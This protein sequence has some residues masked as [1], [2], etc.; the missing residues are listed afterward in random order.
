[1][2]ADKT[3]L[4]A[5]LVVATDPELLTIGAESGLVPILHRVESLPLAL[6]ALDHGDIAAVFAGPGLSALDATALLEQA[7]FRTDAT[8]ILALDRAAWDPG[9][10]L[11][12]GLVQSCLL[13]PWTRDD[14]TWVLR[15]AVGRWRVDRAQA[16][17]AAA[18][19]AHR[20]QTV[21]LASTGDDLRAPLDTIVGFSELVLSLIEA[22]ELERL[23]GYLGAITDAATRMR[24]TLDDLLDMSRLDLGQSPPREDWIDVGDA[25]QAALRLVGPPAA[26]KRQTLAFSIADRFPRLKGDGRLLRQSL[27]HILTNATQY[28]PEGGHI[29][30]RAWVADGLISLA[31]ADDGVGIAAADIPRLLHPAH[32]GGLGLTLARGLIEMHGGRLDLT[33]E[34]GKGT[35]VQVTFPPD[36]CAI[37]PDMP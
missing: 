19:A 20:A 23:G 10:L 15:A 24:R 16:A 9:P 13:A 6:T 18:Q 35:R 31:V 30:V 17:R 25:I 27:L 21:F 3:G 28:T 1:M 37:R 4:P 29:E 8:R 26:D 14:L 2:D 11:D 12:Q 36:R 32:S 22:H 7:A 33:S 34:L 5:V